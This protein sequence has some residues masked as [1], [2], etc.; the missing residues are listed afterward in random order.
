MTFDSFIF[1]KTGKNEKFPFIVYLM[2]IIGYNFLIIPGS[3]DSSPLEHNGNVTNFR[4]FPSLTFTESKW[5]KAIPFQQHSIFACHKMLWYPH[6]T[7]S[8]MPFTLSL[9]Q[10]LL[11]W[12]LIQCFLISYNIFTL[13]RQGFSI[14]Q[15]IICQRYSSLPSTRDVLLPKYSEH[16]AGNFQFIKYNQPFYCCVEL[17]FHNPIKRS[18]CL[19][20]S[21]IK[22][23]F[24]KDETAL[25]TKLSINWFKF[26]AG[27]IF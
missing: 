5:R 8:Q 18:L 2:I 4:T 25:S 9:C 6:S 1:T 26:G 27:R 3:S 17:S 23:G 14:I 7:L 15:T 20:M 24:P 19:F 11:Y 13:F 21:T 16:A 10:Y 12:T 22:R